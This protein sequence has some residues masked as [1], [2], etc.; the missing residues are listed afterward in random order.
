MRLPN[1]SIAARLTPVTFPPGR[2][3]PASGAARIGGPQHVATSCQSLV[4]SGGARCLV[5]P[6]LGRR[7]RWYQAS[8][9]AAVS[10]GDYVSVDEAFAGFA[11]CT[12]GIGNVAGRINTDP[13]G[14][15]STAKCVRRTSH[16]AKSLLATCGPIRHVVSIEIWPRMLVLAS[17]ALRR[18]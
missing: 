12:V 4:S 9:L 8:T 10:H 14:G 5:G 13:P 17:H 2:C 1:S 11:E 3:M 16:T 18:S 7:R 6:E 15:G